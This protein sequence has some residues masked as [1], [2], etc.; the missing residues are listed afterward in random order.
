M[1]VYKIIDCD[2]LCHYYDAHDNFIEVMEEL[3]R[4]TLSMTDIDDKVDVSLVEMSEEDFVKIQEK[5]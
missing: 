3:E 1:L 2:G 5:E 4:D